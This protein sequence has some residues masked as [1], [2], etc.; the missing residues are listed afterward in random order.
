[1]S[2]FK[3]QI[4]FDFNTMINTDEFA[5]IVLNLRTN[6]SFGAIKNDAYIGVDNEGMPITK[7]TPII[8]LQLKIDIKQHDMLRIDG[9]DFLVFEIQKDGIDGQDVYLKYA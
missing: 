7:D 2:S 8:N 6:E 4:G 9:I 5:S 3:D 1:M